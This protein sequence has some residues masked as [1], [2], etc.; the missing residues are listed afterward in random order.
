MTELESRDYLLILILKMN[1]KENI[2]ETI[3]QS[4]VVM[5]HSSQHVP[6]IFVAFK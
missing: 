6:S 3:K 5:H 2:T 1:I 4:D